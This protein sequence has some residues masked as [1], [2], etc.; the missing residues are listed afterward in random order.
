MRFD[1]LPVERGKDA[2]D[3]S[4]A[5]DAPVACVL[6]T[7]TAHSSENFEC[8]TGGSCDLK[9]AW[10]HWSYTQHQTCARLTAPLILET[11]VVSK[12]KQHLLQVAA[13]WTP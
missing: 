1:L 13:P 5:R 6:L 8:H 12:Q 10:L 7:F 3:L 9:L 2:A 11:E 4:D